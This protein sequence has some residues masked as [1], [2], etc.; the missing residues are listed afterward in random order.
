MK[1]DLFSALYRLRHCRHVPTSEADSPDQAQRPA[2]VAVR[3]ALWAGDA[4]PA[5]RHFQAL[6]ALPAAAQEHCINDDMTR[7][8][9]ELERWNGAD[10]LVLLHE[11]ARQCPLSIWPRLLEASYW[12]MRLVELLASQ[13]DVELHDATPWNDTTIVMHLVYVQVLALLGQGPMDWKLAQLLL[14][15]ERICDVPEWVN[16]WCAGNMVVE[17]P[18]QDLLLEQASDVL[19]SRGIESAWWPE[20]PAQCPALLRHAHDAIGSQ[21]TQVASRWLYIGIKTSPYGLSCL[22]Q[23]ALSNLTYCTEP[24]ELDA[25]QPSLVKLAHASAI[26][27]D[28][29]NEIRSLFWRQEIQALG[30]QPEQRHL[31][32]SKA[33][34]ALRRLPL[35]P[36][37]RADILYILLNDLTLCSPND[38]E[39][40]DKL[41]KLNVQWQRYRYINQLLAMPASAIGDQPLEQLIRVW[42]KQGRQA[43]WCRPIIEAKRY[44]DA[45]SA[46]FYGVLCDNGW[47]GLKRNTF[48]AVEWYRYAVALAP[49]DGIKEFN[50]QHCMG[51]PFSRVFLLLSEEKGNDV[52]F[53][54]LLSFAAEAGYSDAQYRH[55]LFASLAPNESEKWI[56]KSLRE[57][58]LDTFIAHYHLGMLYA[59][60]LKNADMSEIAAQTQGSLVF[61]AM[62][63]FMAYL[64][65]FLDNRDKEWRLGDYQ[66]IEQIMF[67]AIEH[68]CLCPDVQPMYTQALHRL[69]LDFRNDIHLACSVTM[70]AYLYGREDSPIPHFDMAV[71]MVVGMRQIFPHAEMVHFISGQLRNQSLS[72]QQRF[73]KIAA[74]ASMDDLPGCNMITPPQQRVCF[75]ELKN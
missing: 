28:D 73:D 3:D 48:K 47:A 53:S 7:L 65:L 10:T 26:T 62:H 68:L 23:V 12:Q 57:G 16:K 34:Y 37:V 75:D 1:Y 31:A 8:I 24:S 33:R 61:K 43:I 13:D 74:T 14:A 58:M 2:M 39:A 72:S 32:L 30:R 41:P 52:H 44:T 45:F 6:L 11:W 55:G 54:H 4:M 46:V 66:Q 64:Q 38:A 9:H 69:L 70:L 19:L 29:I 35:S 21:G 42:N 63:H 25:L 27:E 36:S 59:G 56:L 17:L 49:P 50:L 51:E 22:K 60:C 15:S 18:A 67:R 5:D 40:P 71:R 20:L